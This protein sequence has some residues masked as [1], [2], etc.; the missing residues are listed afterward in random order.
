MFWFVCQDARPSQLLSHSGNSADTTALH[1]NCYR[2]FSYIVLYLPSSVPCS[3]KALLQSMLHSSTPRRFSRSDSI[4][5][6][7][8]T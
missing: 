8:A 1:L 7:R 3:E 5:T 6:E 2:A 4:A